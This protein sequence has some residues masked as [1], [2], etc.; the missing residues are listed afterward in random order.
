MSDERGFLSAIRSKRNDEAT[1]LVYAD[2]LDD[3]GDIRADFLRL[4]LALRG[5]SPDHVQ[6]VAGEQEMSEL[7][8]E[9][10]PAWLA[11]VEPERRI[12]D[13]HADFHVLPPEEDDSDD[14]EEVWEYPSPVI[15][16]D[17]YPTCDCD[18]PSGKRGKR[19]DPFLHGDNQD[20]ECEPWKHL[21]EMVEEAAADG[22]EEFAPFRNM[23]RLGRS[24]IV[25][26]PS[27]I[28]KLT[29]VKHLLLYGSNLVRLPPEIGRM[30]ALERFT[31]YTSYRLHWFPYEITH[32]RN[33]IDS[34]VSTRALFGNYKNRPPFPDLRPPRDG[35]GAFREPVRLPLKRRAAET[36]R[37]CS[38]CRQPFPDLQR[39][40]YWI[41][42]RVATDVLPLL[43]N[44][45][46]EECVRRL[47]PPPDGYIQGPHRGGRDV[48]QPPTRF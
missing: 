11:I 19:P 39:H 29:R 40:R 33:L 27:T 47:P 5:C 1:R 22:R 12:V 8:R 16:P 20:T 21:L 18:E 43:V 28:A 13:P 23:T 48:Q 41:S 15:S 34:T 44:A 38:V 3:R 42:L 46:S 35:A 17:P 6:R 36:L 26:L 4:H 7:R 25:T 10:D 37:E 24:Q 14:G 9:I 30:T 32:C 45:C 31:P 2:W